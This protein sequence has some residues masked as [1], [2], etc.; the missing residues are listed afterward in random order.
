MLFVTA[1][2]RITLSAADPE[3]WMLEPFLELLADAA[4]TTAT[5]IVLLALWEGRTARGRNVRMRWFGIRTTNRR[6]GVDD[7]LRA[8]WRA[9]CQE[10]ASANCVIRPNRW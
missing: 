2:I 9:R 10:P 4:D 1:R 6:I 7:F 3:A 8:A 5:I